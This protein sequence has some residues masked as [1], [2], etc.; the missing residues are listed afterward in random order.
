MQF[1]RVRASTSHQNGSRLRIHS[2]LEEVDG[3][4]EE[5][6]KLKVRVV[7]TSFPRLAFLE[8]HFSI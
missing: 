6:V 4:N 5:A 3:E 2:G 8:Y 7:S 1:V